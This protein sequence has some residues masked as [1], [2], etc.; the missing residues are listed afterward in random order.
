MVEKLLR[1]AKRCCLF[2]LGL[3]LPACSIAA[4]HFYYPVLE[5][6]YTLTNK[7]CRHHSKISSS[8]KLCGRCLLECIDSRYCQSCW[9]FSTSFVNYYA[10]KL[11][12]GSTLPPPFLCQSTVHTDSVWYRGGGCWILLETI[13][14]RSVTLCIW[15]DSETTQLIDLTPNKNLAGDV[16]V[17]SLYR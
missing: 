11:L 3:M 14:C 7:L 4:K 12:S 2:I 5:R 9:Y 8:K 13:F 10:S 6:E 1:T 15:P 16:A 17:K